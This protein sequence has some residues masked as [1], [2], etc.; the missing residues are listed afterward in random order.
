VVGYT[1]REVFSKAAIPLLSECCTAI[2]ISFEWRWTTY[3]ITDIPVCLIVC[4]F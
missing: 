1:I 3:A 4:A 2:S